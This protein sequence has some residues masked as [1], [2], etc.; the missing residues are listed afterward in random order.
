[1]NNEFTEDKQVGT[2]GWLSVHK[3]YEKSTEHTRFQGFDHYKMLATL[4]WPAIVMAGSPIKTQWD[5]VRVLSF[6]V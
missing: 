5:L 1:M 4:N 3:N 6:Q 2:Y